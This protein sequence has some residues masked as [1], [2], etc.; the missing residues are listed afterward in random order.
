MP[1][2]HALSPDVHVADVRGDLV[3]LDAR[4]DEYFCLPKSGADRLRAAIRGLGTDVPETVELL[5]ELRSVGLL[6]SGATTAPAPSYHHPRTANGDVAEEQA[7]PAPRPKEVAK[8][9]AAT[10]LALLTLRYRAPRSW[11]RRDRA[12]SP[13]TNVDA[14]RRLANVF[15]VLRT[16][17]PKSGRCLPSSMMLL[18]FL[19]LHNVR[20]AWVFGVRTHPFEA[21]CW[22]ECDGIV[23]NDSLEHVRWFTP[24]LVA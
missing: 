17:V 11:F 5:T 21:H 22:I 8:F 2:A 1:L 7:R 13:C 18:A 9:I 24:I 19:R 23:L 10:F 20:A 15:Q 4:Q 16:F 6:V 12:S 3:F 14:A